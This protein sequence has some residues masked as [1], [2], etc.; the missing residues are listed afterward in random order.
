MYDC[1]FGGVQAF[2]GEQFV[3]INGYSNMFHGWGGEDDDLLRR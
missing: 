3:K 2:N 1:Y